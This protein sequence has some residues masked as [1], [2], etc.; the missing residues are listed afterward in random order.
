MT[1]EERDMLSQ[2]GIWTIDALLQYFNSILETRDQKYE[3]QFKH[4]QEAVSAALQS[5]EKA[6]SKAENS[7]EKRFE[8]VNEFRAVLSDQQRMLMTRSEYE[9]NHRNL[10]TMFESSIAAINEKVNNITIN[11]EKHESTGTGSKNALGI[12]AGAFGLILTIITI[13]FIVIEKAG[14]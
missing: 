3:Q 7:N 5:S 12:M 2:S 11:L 6:I 14:K 1:Q 9:V 10:I 8:S 13:V 4:Q